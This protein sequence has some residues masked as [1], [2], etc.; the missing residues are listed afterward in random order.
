MLRH[1]G[2]NDV[3]RESG[4]KGAIGVGSGD[5]SGDDFFTSVTGARV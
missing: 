3:N 5:L 1:A 4:T 2:L